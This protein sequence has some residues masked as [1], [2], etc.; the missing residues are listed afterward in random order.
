MTSEQEPIEAYLDELLG[1]LRG[2]ASVVRGTLAEAEAHLRDAADE[3][4]ESGMEPTEAQQLAVARFG[5]A[6]EVAAAANRFAVGGAVRSLAPAAISA[7]GRVA[8]AGLASIGLAALLAHAL[9]LVTSRGFVFGRPRDVVLEAADCS[10]W[11]GAQPTAASCRQAA[12]LENASDSLVL[13]VVASIVGLVIVAAAFAIARRLWGS[14]GAGVFGSRLP[15]GIEPAIGA[16]LFG[17][18]AL[19]LLVASVSDIALPGL[20]GRGLWLT[21]A[22]VALCVAVTYAVG[23]VRRASLDRLSTAPLI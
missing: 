14:Q 1:R 19:V 16:T 17:F 4:I 15:Y 12:T 23:F 18:A 8:A 13:P 10:R 6:R 9:A 11:L 5:S 22:A 7:V 2:P 20:W 21:D 3:A